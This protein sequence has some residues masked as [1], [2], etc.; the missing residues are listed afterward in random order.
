MQ[1]QVWGHGQPMSVQMV[2]S[3]P[4]NAVPVVDSRKGFPLKLHGEHW[5]SIHIAYV[6]MKHHGQSTPDVDALMAE[7]VIPTLDEAVGGWRSI[8]IRAKDI[9]PMVHLLHYAASLPFQ[10][11][12]TLKKR[13]VALSKIDPND[14]LADAA[15]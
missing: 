3:R 15:R 7:E 2:K 11:G 1:N 5:K 10:S 13:A 12:F 4:T 8:R 6:W 9:A 14:L